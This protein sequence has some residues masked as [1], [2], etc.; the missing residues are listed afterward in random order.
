MTVMVRGTHC[1]GNTALGAVSYEVIT[2][3]E[4]LTMPKKGANAGARLSP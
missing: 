2:C 3:L 1:K 4:V